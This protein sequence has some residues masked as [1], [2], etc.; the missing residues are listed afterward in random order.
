MPG[1]FSYL[2]SHVPNLSNYE[3]IWICFQTNY[4]YYWIV[5]FYL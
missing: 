2:Q 4:V 3:G 5:S 1:E